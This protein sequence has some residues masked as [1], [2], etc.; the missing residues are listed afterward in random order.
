MSSNSFFSY[1]FELIIHSINASHFITSAPTGAGIL[2]SSTLLDQLIE[3]A[4]EMDM[5]LI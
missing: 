4:P 5:S 3:M 2:V 1:I